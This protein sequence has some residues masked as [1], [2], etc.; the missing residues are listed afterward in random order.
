MT[1]DER[2]LLLSVASAMAEILEAG[3][4]PLDT[5]SDHAGEL[6][7]LLDR[8]HA[9]EAEGKPTRRLERRERPKPTTPLTSK[10]R[11]PPDRGPAPL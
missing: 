6:R 1:R 3:A 7:A 8:M 10:R 4:A 2:A 11:V 5:I 9:Q